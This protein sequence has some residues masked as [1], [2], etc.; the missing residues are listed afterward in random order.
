MGRGCAQ[1]QPSGSVNEYLFSSFGS[2]G[3]LSARTG[4]RHLILAVCSGSV[5]VVG[6]VLIYVPMLRR[7]PILLTG[8][9]WF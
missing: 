3:R 4:K 1:Y 9:S 7:P 6:L 5:L 8:G 2:V